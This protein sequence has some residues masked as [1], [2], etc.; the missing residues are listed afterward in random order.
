MLLSMRL[1]YRLFQCYL[2]FCYLELL[3]NSQTIMFTI[4]IAQNLN[5]KIHSQQPT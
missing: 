3:V 4:T 1:N 2:C 5:Y